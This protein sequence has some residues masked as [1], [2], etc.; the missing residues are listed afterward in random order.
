MYRGRKK[1]TV[2]KFILEKLSE[3]GELAID[4]LFP[5]NRSESRI[6]REMLSLPIGYEFSKPTFSLI[7][8]R[9]KKDGLVKRTGGKRYALW[10]ITQ[11]GKDKLKSYSYS[12]KP[13]Q[14]DGI[15]RLVMYDIPEKERKKRDLLRYELLA[16]N[17]KQLQ[18]SVWLGYCPLPEEFVQTL[19]DMGLGGKVH[20]VSINKRGT[21]SEF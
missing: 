21:L 13:A 1:G 9:L 12:M 2:S 8:S 17:Y 3:I 7:L 4:G 20:I 14:P 19:K 6:W 10:R 16:C 5:P 18:R 11:K 15:P